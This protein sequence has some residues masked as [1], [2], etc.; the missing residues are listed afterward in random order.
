MRCS[1]L[2][3]DTGMI[4]GNMG[5]VT[6]ALAASSRK[7]KKASVSKKNWVMARVA[8]ASHL[9]LQDIDVMVDGRLSGCTW[10]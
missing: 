2:K 3:F 10:G 9:G 6:P 4:P 7:R 5:M 8:P 1:P